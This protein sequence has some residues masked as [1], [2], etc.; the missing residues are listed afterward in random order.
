MVCKHCGT[1]P[2]WEHN[3][4]TYFC[5]ICRVAIDRMPIKTEHLKL[6]KEKNERING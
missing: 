6:H 2:D 3:I 5:N 4:E 1:E